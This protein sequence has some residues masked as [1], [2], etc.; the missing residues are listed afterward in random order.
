MSD[1]I[2]DILQSQYEEV[3]WQI[4]VSFAG[5]F[6]EVGTYLTDEVTNGQPW[7]V[8][9]ED[10]TN[11]WCFNAAIIPEDYG[12]LYMNIPLDFTQY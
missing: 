1:E 9:M 10:G 8:L 12:H 7:E 2:C 11:Y 5:K 3:I 6:T 4:S